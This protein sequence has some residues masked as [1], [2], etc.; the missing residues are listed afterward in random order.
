MSQNNRPASG[1]SRPQRPMF[2]QENPGAQRAVYRT[3]AGGSAGGARVS[4]RTPNQV[5]VRRANPTAARRRK[6]KQ[7]RVRAFTILV[8]LLLIAGVGIFAFYNMLNVVHEDN[9]DLGGGDIPESVGTKDVYPEYTGKDIINILICGVH[10]EDTVNADGTVIKD[11]V[12]NTDMIMYLSYNT[13]LGTANMLQI[14]RDVFVG[15]ADTAKTAGGTGKINGLWAGSSDAG[16]RMAPLIQLLKDQYKL[17]VDAYINLDMEALKAIMGT[18]PGPLKVYVPQD[19]TYTNAGGAL[20]II[21]AGWRDIDAD[22]AEFLL[23]NRYGYADQSDISRLATQLHFYAALFRLFQ[24][25]SPADLVMYTKILLHYANVEGLDVFNFG[26]DNVAA[27]AIEA[28]SLKPERITIVRPSVSG[29]MNGNQA[30]VC[31]VPQ[32]FCE[33]LNTYFRPA[34][35]GYTLE[36]LN[37]PPPLPDVNGWGTILSRIVTMADVEASEG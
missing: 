25:A 34:G 20:N 26:Q 9:A 1:Q 23:R 33:Q 37:I 12:G 29:A 14:P 36:E 5:A 32:E 2:D 10:K 19:I 18:L 6:R 24:T 7:R 4:Y 16:N 8:C 28:L 35:H 30:L 13:T 31:L 22:S 27:L 15:Q 3:A 21:P 11:T 17:P